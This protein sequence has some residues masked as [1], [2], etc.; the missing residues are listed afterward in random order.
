MSCLR[1]AHAEDAHLM[2]RVTRPSWRASANRVSGSSPRPTP[3]Q[4]TADSCRRKRK[5]GNERH[6]LA[7]DRAAGGAPGDTLRYRPESTPAP[8]VRPLARCRVPPYTRLVR[9]LSS[10]GG[11]LARRFDELPCQGFQSLGRLPPLPSEVLVLA[12]ET[13]GFFFIPLAFSLGG[14]GSGRDLLVLAEQPGDDAQQSLAFRHPANDEIPGVAG[15]RLGQSGALFEFR[16][17]LGHVPAP[18]R[19]PPLH[20][21]KLTDNDEP[22][23]TQPVVLASPPPPVSFPSVRFV[24]VALASPFFVTSIQ[25][26]LNLLVARELPPQVAV[27]VWVVPCRD[28]EVLNHGGLPLTGVSFRDEAADVSRALGIDREYAGY[29]TPPSG[30]GQDGHCAGVSLGLPRDNGGISTTRRAKSA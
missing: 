7:G 16:P 26:D 29:F 12:P 3:A 18:P 15:F 19:W 8:S 9:P 25:K 28:H 13:P 1:E 2:A 20:S 24:R 11:Y 17:H 5:E 21:G 4:G 22:V 27:K 30:R 14:L 23:G 6:T 10:R